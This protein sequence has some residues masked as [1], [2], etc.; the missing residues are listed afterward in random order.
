MSEIEI[1]KGYAPGAIGRVTELHASY[2]QQHWGFGL[3]FEAKVATELA[4]FLEHYDEH[5]DGIW[6]ARING[7]IEGSIAIDGARAATEGAHLRWYLM[8]DEVRGQGVGQRS[9]E[10]AIAFCRVQ[11]YRSVYLWTFEGLDAARHVYEK[12][13]FRL[14]EQRRG[15]RWGREVNEQRFVLD[16]S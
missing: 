5:R 13:G 6:V 10:T 7:S 4:S 9:I 16:L 3:F 8:S 11:R 12:N 14:V 1:V 2:Y 15:T